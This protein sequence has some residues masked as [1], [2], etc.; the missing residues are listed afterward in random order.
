MVLRL[1]NSVSVAS[2]TGIDMTMS[3]KLI[4][5]SDLSRYTPL[6]ARGNS[7]KLLERPD[8]YMDGFPPYL[9]FDF[10]G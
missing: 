9:V 3:E 5:E 7:S 10:R 6:G 1:P 4:I 2:L 8:L